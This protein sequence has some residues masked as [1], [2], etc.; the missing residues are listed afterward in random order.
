MGEQQAIQLQQQGR[1]MISDEGI[2]T[3][4]GQEMGQLR[5]VDFEDP[6]SL[7]REGTNRYRSAVEPQPAQ[8]RVV[9]GFLESSN[10]NSLREM[11]EL[12][13]AHRSFDTIQQAIQSYREMDN[14]ANEIGRP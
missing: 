1:V 8:P 12:I 4:N 6:T 9:Q 3:V 10:V 13:S 7:V 2:V 11:V 5:R 14:R